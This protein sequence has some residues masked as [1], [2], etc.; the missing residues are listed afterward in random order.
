MA[1]LSRTFFG[2]GAQPP[3]TFA[4]SIG[5]FLKRA[6]ELRPKDLSRK[7]EYESSREQGPGAGASPYP[8]SEADDAPGAKSGSG[9][10]EFE[11]M[12]EVGNQREE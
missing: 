10:G 2:A 12:G 1:R 11:R 4:N 9:R 8:K 6:A 7:I 5:R 3:A